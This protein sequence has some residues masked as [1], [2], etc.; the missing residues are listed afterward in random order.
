[1]RFFLVQVIDTV[2]T[3]GKSEAITDA[4]I[5]EFSHFRSQTPASLFTSREL[6]C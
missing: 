2:W 4:Q 5:R 3:R 1:M 6:G